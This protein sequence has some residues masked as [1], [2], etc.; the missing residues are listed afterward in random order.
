MG[1]NLTIICYSQ[2]NVKGKAKL[3]DL[4][5]KQWNTHFAICSKDDF[6]IR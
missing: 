6:E 3:L 1:H 5:D 2:I 4:F